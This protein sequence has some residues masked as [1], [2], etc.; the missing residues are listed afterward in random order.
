[1]TIAVLNEKLA[2]SP[3]ISPADVAGIA[4]QGYEQFICNRPD[5]EAEDQPFIKDIEAEAEKYGMKVVYAPVANNQFTD[6]A[7]EATKQGLA[8]GWKTLMFCRTGTRSSI[9]WSII[10]VR[11]GRDVDEVLAQAK[12][13]GYDLANMREVITS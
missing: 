6:E 4:Q 1:M 11:E 12:T 10:Q 3:Q 2:F 8:S 13:V 5:Q 7:V 9:L